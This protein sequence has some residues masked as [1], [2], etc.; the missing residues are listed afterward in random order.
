[1]YLYDVHDIE[2]L[3]ELRSE[4]RVSPHALWEVYKE[5]LRGKD[6]ICAIFRGRVIE[7]YP[8][9]R[10][11]LIVG[12]TARSDLPLHVVCDYTDLEQIVAVTAYIPS[13]SVWAADMVRRA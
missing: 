13:R 4:L 12:P 10:R 6:I 3:L 1:M 2:D 7:N 9:R 11:V 5:G 8:D